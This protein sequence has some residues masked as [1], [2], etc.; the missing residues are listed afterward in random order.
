MTTLE[1][2]TLV[3]VGGSSG[4]G[5]AVAEASLISLA[6]HVVIASANPA[7]VQSAVQRLEQA[8]AGKGLPGKISSATFD[9]TDLP[10]VKD[11]F[12][13]LGEIDHLIWTSGDPLKLGFPN[14]DITELKGSLYISQGSALD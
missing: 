8:I 1:G 12:S 3:I 14:V 4:I 13:S 11:Y 5:F 7:R 9:V 6:S 2:K 10:A